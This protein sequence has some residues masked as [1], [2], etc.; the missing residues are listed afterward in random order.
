MS[1][2]D[3][4]DWDKDLQAE[5]EEEY[6][7]LVRAL[8]WVNGFG[9]YFVRCSTAEGE[10]LIE[11]VRQD[12]S[13][14]HIEVLKLTEPIEN[15]YDRIKALPN[16]DQ[17]DVLFIQGI[18]HSLYDYEK[19]KLWE[20]S[21][22]RY[23]Y[24]WKGVPRL[25]G[26]LNLSRERFKDFDICFVFL[27]PRFALRYLIHRAP[28]FFDWHSGVF[29]FVMDE[30]GLQSESSKIWAEANYKKYCL[31]SPQD[32][33]DK[34]LSV[35]SL[36]EE[37]QLPID[38]K[39]GLLLEQG[40][41]FAADQNF[42]AAIAAYDA[43]LAIKPDNHEALNNKGIALRKLGRYEE[44][45]ASY[46]AALAIKPDKHDALNSKGIALGK[47]GRYEEAIAS[48]DAA[49][50]I[51]PDK[52]DAL[53]NK[54]IALGK[55]GRYEEA[56]ASYDAALAIKPDNHEA[57]NNKGNALGEL[58]RYEEAIAAY[59]A[60]LAIKPDNHQALYNKGYALRQLG[61]YE[62]AIA[63][64]D[65]ALAIKPDYHQ[66]LYNKGYALRQL[67]RYEEAIAVGL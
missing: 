1:Q 21:K 44:A 49:L 45:I 57:L 55:L 18:E 53:N 27:V 64:Y 17:L 25:L 41:L 36:L 5:P 48:Y 32:R 9:L 47:L 37:D 26:H 24:S 6:Q 65:A 60:A 62:E 59:D 61:R 54:G 10:R 39:L 52:H 22:D 14:K 38:Q 13:S 63:A 11:R 42:E 19:H 31:L 56:I 66:A 29:E 46:D 35:Q 15:F 30:E 34:I 20:S 3:L 23:G 33:R 50:A 58:G 7:A 51:K 12:V 43:A 16:R 8:H 4:T 40:N 28:D 67:G 2:A